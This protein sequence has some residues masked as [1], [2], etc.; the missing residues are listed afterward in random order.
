MR[1]INNQQEFED[2]FPYD[3][4]ASIKQYPKEYPC[5]CTWETEGGGIMGDYRQVYVAYFPKNV[6]VEEAFVLGLKQPLEP[7][8]NK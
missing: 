5:V 2:F 1:V 3:N 8:I 7:I 6:S 4:K